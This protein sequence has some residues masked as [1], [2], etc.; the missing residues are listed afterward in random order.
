[1]KRTVLFSSL[2][3]STVFSAAALA[4]PAPKTLKCGVWEGEKSKPST[5]FSEVVSLQGSGDNAIFSAYKTVYALNGTV[6]IEVAAIQAIGTSA[7]HYD[8]V[9]INLTDTTNGVGAISSGPG[10][11]L[12]EKPSTNSDNAFINYTVLDP[13]DN[14]QVGRHVTVECDLQLLS[15]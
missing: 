8:A 2:V 5:T 12:L 11:G 7:E 4:T 15:F 3:L 10:M 13:K 6:K 1:M 14:S 9:I